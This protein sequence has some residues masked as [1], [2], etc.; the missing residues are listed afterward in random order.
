M[1]A[2]CHCDQYGSGNICL[3]SF[4]GQITFERRIGGRRCELITKAV[5]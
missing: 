1:R 5:C 2:V 3:R 4:V